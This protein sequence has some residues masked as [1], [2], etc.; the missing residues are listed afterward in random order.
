MAKKRKA[1]Q[2]ISDAVPEA[3]KTQNAKGKETTITAASGRSR[4]LTVKP[5]AL[6]IL[7]A[8]E[9]DDPT[10]PSNKAER[11]SGSAAVPAASAKIQA[12]DVP[13]SRSKVSDTSQAQGTTT[14]RKNSG[15]SVKAPHHEEGKEK[16]Q[17]EDSD[18]LDQAEHEG[19][20]VNYWLMKAEPESRIVKGKDVKFSI[21]DLK[22]AKEPEAWD[23]KQPELIFDLLTVLIL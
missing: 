23:G 6:A 4:R 18:I 11:N 9:P 21:D 13:K 12:P 20:E 19:N 5:E 17:Q 16:M 22:A 7:K 14:T 2:A 1:N 8:L 10:K 3:I 15:R